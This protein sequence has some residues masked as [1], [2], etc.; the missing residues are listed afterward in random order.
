MQNLDDLGILVGEGCQRVN[1]REKI[2]ELEFCY[3]I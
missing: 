1:V 2:T 3:K